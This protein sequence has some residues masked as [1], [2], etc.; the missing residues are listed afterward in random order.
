M[1]AMRGTSNVVLLTLLGGGAFGNDDEWIL[2]AM[3]RGFEQ[4]LAFELDARIVSY[5]APP[6]TVLTLVK[7]FG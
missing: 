6:P 5:R 7:D 1:N 2:G 4:V 3:Q